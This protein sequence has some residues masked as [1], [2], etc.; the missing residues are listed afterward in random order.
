[1]PLT[2]VTELA[3]TV[4]VSVACRTNRGRLRF[5]PSRANC[6]EWQAPTLD[7]HL[8]SSLVHGWVLEDIIV[9]HRGKGVAGRRRHRLVRA[10]DEVERR[11]I[12]VGP[13]AIQLVALQQALRDECLGLL[14][15]R[16]RTLSVQTCSPAVRHAGL[17]RIHVKGQQAP[18]VC[19]SGADICGDLSGATNASPAGLLR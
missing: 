8:S 16:Q 11:C 15:K 10:H 6:A 17:A 19:T 5:A 2:N 7:T 4:A 12:C 1:M 9:S 18:Q 3:V 13:D 14:C